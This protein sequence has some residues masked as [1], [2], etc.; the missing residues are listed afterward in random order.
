MP[1]MT[2]MLKMALYRMSEIHVCSKCLDKNDDKRTDGNPES[3]IFKE[4]HTT[5]YFAKSLVLSNDLH[6]QGN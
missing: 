4:I 2:R 5:C 1:A 3:I 6:L